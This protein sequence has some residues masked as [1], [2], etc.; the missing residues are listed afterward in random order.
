[1]FLYVQFNEFLRVSWQWLW[2]VSSRM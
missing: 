2:R 1:V